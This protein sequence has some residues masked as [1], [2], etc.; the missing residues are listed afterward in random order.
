MAL[1][2]AVATGNWSNPAIWNAGVL[3]V[4]GDVVA[5]NGFTVTIDQDVNVDLLTNTVQSPVV[6]TPAMTSYTTPSGIV[7]ASSEYP[8]TSYA[9]WRLFDRTSSPWLTSPPVNTGWN[10]YE[11]TSTKIVSKYILTP[12]T[13]SSPGSIPRNWTFEGWNGTDWVVL[14]TVTG[15][16]S[17]ANVTR[18]FVNT[19]AFIKYRINITA[20]NGHIYVGVQELALYEAND[21]GA[22]SVAGGGFVLNSGITCTLTN[23]SSGISYI[24]TTPVITWNGAAGTTANIVANILAGAA[25]AGA[26]AG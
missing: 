1:R 23:A 8:E 26:G 4:A 13:L 2:V 21:Y 11:F 16:S 17:T 19:V 10:A 3:P 20:N 9:A 18:S 22:N 25:G 15:N 14:D 6:L 5:S 12:T 24:S 7:T